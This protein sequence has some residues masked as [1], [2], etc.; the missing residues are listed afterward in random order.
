MS[1][2]PPSHDP[3]TCAARI[4][5]LEETVARAQQARDELVSTV[6]H[7]LR[8][9]LN[10]I[11]VALDGLRD[12]A[13]GE[14]AHDRYVGAIQRSIDKAER[15][16]RDLVTAHHIESGRLQIERRPVALRPLLEQVARDHEVAATQAKSRIVV[17]VDERVGSIS[18]DRDRLAQ[19]LACLIANALR[20]GR[21]TPTVE[22]SARPAADGGVTLAV[23]DHGPGIAEDAL[24]HVFDRTWNGH[25]K[26]GG[27]GLQIVRGIARAHGG[28]AHAARGDDGG[29]VFTIELPGA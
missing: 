22:L 15:L 7:D 2:N 9:P 25:T 29:A 14:G 27:L 23:R 6:S 19:A 10:T 8:G 28:D 18:A 13:A 12:A 1:S 5:E 21:G 16:I 11:G 3:E 24:P 4:A 20:H 26:K 17:D